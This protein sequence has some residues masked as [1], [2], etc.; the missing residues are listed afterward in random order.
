MPINFRFVP[1]YFDFDWELKIDGT[2]TLGGRVILAPTPSVPSPYK[3]TFSGAQ[4]F[5]KNTWKF[6]VQ[7]LRYANAPLYQP[8]KLKNYSIGVFVVYEVNSKSCY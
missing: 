8:H 7:G 5:L 6:L 3:A 4:I 2:G 1:F